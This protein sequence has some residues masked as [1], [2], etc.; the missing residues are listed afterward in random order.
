MM[1][2]PVAMLPAVKV[3][4]KF[5]DRKTGEDVVI[6]HVDR[7]FISWRDQNSLGYGRMLRCHFG[8]FYQRKEMG[9]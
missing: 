6:S 1:S 7:E 9:A 5:T 8:K 3:G 2:A 4:Q